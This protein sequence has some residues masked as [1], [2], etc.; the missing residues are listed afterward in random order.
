MKK[1]IWIG[2]LSAG[3]ALGG[4][5]SVSA[6]SKGTI[7]SSESS[8]NQEYISMDKAKEIALKKINGTVKSIELDHKFNHAYYEVEIKKNHIDFDV[9]VDAVTGN[10]RGVHKDVE[11]KD[12][13][14]K[15]QDISVTKTAITAE[16][17]I[18]IAKKE[19]DGTVT[20]V[21]KDED[22]GIIKYEVELQSNQGEVDI[23]IDANTGKIIEIDYED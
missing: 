9:Y 18:S 12:E 20:K 23:D 22:D 17:A 5:L 1:K 21:E 4:A 14:Y 3:I 16:Q 19:I 6:M 13:I 8:A 10:I 11:D 7:N 15:N 2:V